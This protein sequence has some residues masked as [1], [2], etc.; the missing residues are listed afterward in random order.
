MTAAERTTLALM[1]SCGFCWAAP[2]TACARQGQHLARYLRAGGVTGT[3]PGSYPRPQAFEEAVRQSA[4]D[5]T[6]LRAGGF[7]SNT[8]A[9]APVVRSQRM[10]FAPFG[11][12]A[13]PFIDPADIGEAAAVALRDGGHAER[14]YVLTGPEPVSPREQ[15]RAIGEALGEAVGFTE[16]S[17]EQAREQMVRFMPEQV[18][19]VTLSIYGEPLA[20]EQLVSPD[21]ERL[22]GRPGRTYAQWARRNADAFR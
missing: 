6:I 17:R 18:A 8:L 7:D 13:L 11:D 10:V 19:D 20:E 1:A 5:W 3:R 12:V 4:L 16:L 21:V 15:A 2:G 9:W 14:V 22:L